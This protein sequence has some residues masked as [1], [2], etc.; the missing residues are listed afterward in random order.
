MLKKIAKKLQ[1]FSFFDKFKPPDFC[2]F[3]IYTFLT[4]MEKKG[5]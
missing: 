4:F 3:M 2:Y 1:F 5:L